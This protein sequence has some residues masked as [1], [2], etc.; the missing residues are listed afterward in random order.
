LNTFY[1]HWKKET[2]GK[3]NVLPQRIIFFRDGLSEGEFKGVAEEEIKEIKGKYLM[4][5]FD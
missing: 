3:K 5:S 2:K 1:T 4:P